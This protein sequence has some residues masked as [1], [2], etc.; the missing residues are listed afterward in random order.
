MSRRIIVTTAAALGLAA[1]AFSQARVQVQTQTPVRT[2]T[3]VVVTGASAKGPTLATYSLANPDGEVSIRAMRD[4]M[5]RAKKLRGNLA[6]DTP[7]LISY[8][9]MD[10][11]TYHVLASLGSVVQAIRFRGRVPNIEVRVGN[12]DLDQTGHILTNYYTGTAYNESWPLDENYMALR[13]S[14]WLATDRQYKTAIESMSRKRA[15]MLTAIQLHTDDRLPNYW[16]VPPSN[17]IDTVTH[18]EVKDDVWNRRM[19]NLSGVFRSYP[20][21]VKSSVDFQIIQ[22]TSLLVNTEGTTVRYADNLNWM[23]SRAEAFAPDGMSVHDGIA[24]PTFDLDK[25]PSEDT[26][27]RQLVDVAEN[28]RSLASAPAADPYVGPVLF[29]PQAAAQLLAQLVGDNLDVPRRPMTD[30]GRNIPFLP[31]Q[32]E[33]KLGSR[34]LPDWIDITEDPH[35]TTWNNQDLIGFFPY[36][37][38]GTVPEVVKVVDRGILKSFLTSRQPVN[39]MSAGNGHARLPG[40]YGGRTA[41]I[42]NMFV[43]AS[44][45]ASMAELKRRL[46]EMVVRQNKPYGMLVRKLDYP[47]TAEVPELQAIQIENQQTSATRPISPPVLVYRVY[48]DG[49]EELVRGLRFRALTVKALKDIAGASSEETKF[50]FVNNGAIFDFPAAGGYMALTSVISPGLL[51]EEIEFEKHQEQM[52]TLAI[53]PPPPLD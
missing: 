46:I 50:D 11:E 6:L 25:F 2:Q 4:E 33:N 10:T 22:G 26:I 38:E 13:N 43:K 29:E 39:G 17:R 48:P 5:A 30:P 8:G 32:F 15:T 3:K 12:Y 19:A 7:Y 20:S 47:T 14:L 40:N 28:V 42:G 1:G 9:L 41:A 27:H 53:V 49:R 37:L 44:Q 34:I 35:A 18:P 31:S 23:T 21:I 36:D 24:I 45:T 52:A 51:F 16:K